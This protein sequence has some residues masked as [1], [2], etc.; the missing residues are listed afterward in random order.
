MLGLRPLSEEKDELLGLARNMEYKEL[1]PKV[2][3]YVFNDRAQNLI[4]LRNISRN[5]TRVYRS[6]HYAVYERPGT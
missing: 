2:R 4:E 1:L 5:W 3:Y 6:G